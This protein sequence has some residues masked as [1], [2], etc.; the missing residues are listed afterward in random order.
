MAVRLSTGARN[1]I[2]DSGVGPLFD[3]DG[4]INFYTGTQPASANDDVTGTLLG[5]VTFSADWIGAFASGTGTL[6]AITSD[7]AADA[8]GTAGWFR[9][10]DVSEGVGASSTT[11]KRIDGAVGTSGAD[12]NFNTVTWVAGGTIAMSSLTITIPA[13]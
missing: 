7:S 13:S 1:A 4:A 12:I 2:G 3:P 11:K 5:T 10:Y 6:A 8:S 9:I